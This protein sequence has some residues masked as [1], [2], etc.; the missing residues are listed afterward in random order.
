MTLFQ[1]SIFISDLELSSVQVNASMAEMKNNFWLGAGI[2]AIIIIIIDLMIPFL[3]PLLGGFIAGFIAKGDIMNAG[4]AGFTAGIFA[5]IV[6]GLVMVAG[7]LSPPIAEYLPQAS[8]GYFLF[9]TITMYL[10]LFALLGG[11]IAGAV[12]R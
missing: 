2:G 8:T 12:R 4:K 6:I 10:A 5:T 11:L 7:M 1:G 9:I 3:G